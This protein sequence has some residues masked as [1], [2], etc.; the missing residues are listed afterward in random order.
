MR[1]AR[2]PSYNFV[3]YEGHEQIVIPARRFS[4]QLLGLAALLVTWPL[5]AMAKYGFAAVVGDWHGIIFLLGVTLPLVVAFAIL[6]M[7][8]WVVGSERI[9]IIGTDLFVRH[10]ILGVPVAARSYRGTD[11]RFLSPTSYMPP[12]S[13]GEP[14]VPF[15]GESTRGALKFRYRGS[16][17]YI[18]HDLLPADAVPVVAWLA[19][20]LPKSAFE[21]VA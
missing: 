13:S 9:A 12:G 7:V 15:L 8:W 14:S 18:A 17:V 1:D 20:R 16:T 11:I 21:V 2:H 19:A 5:A 4:G 3:R 10:A 6:Q